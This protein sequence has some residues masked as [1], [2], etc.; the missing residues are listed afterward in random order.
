MDL[1]D[2]NNN[3]ENPDFIPEMPK[4]KPK[5]V[6]ESRGQKPVKTTSRKPRQEKGAFAGIFVERPTEEI[7]DQVLALRKAVLP[8][9]LT[10]DWDR[11]WLEYLAMPLVEDALATLEKVE[12]G[13]RAKGKLEL[14][15][16][17]FL[18]LA[19]KNKINPPAPTNLTVNVNQQENKPQQTELA[20]FLG[21]TV[22]GDKD[23]QE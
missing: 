12:P 15:R 11:P 10:K 1:S 8:E 9:A 3:K 7:R 18:Y 17:I 16:I 23:G 22:E 21:I 19:S 5:T 6:R 20:T 14:I 4:S 2:Q 13:L